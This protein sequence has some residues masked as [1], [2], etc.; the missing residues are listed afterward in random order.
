MRRSK[1]RPW[2]QHIPRRIRFEVGVREL[3]TVRSSCSGRTTRDLVTYHLVVGIPEYESRKVTITIYNSFAPVVKDV[4]ADGP[5]ESPH[6]YRN[7]S[8]CIWHPRDR[9]EQRWV[10]E[11]G[12]LQ[13]ITHARVHLF[14]EAWWREH[15]QDDWPGEQAPHT[16]KDA[17]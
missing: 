10:H 15:D 6:R 11:D 7:N 9:V 4:I 17:T 5:T 14:K 3:Y 12:L 13:L 2:F 16:D 8:L 1:G